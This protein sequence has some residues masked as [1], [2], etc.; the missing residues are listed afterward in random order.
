MQLLWVSILQ[1]RLVAVVDSIN[2]K[3][4]VFSQLEQIVSVRS[5]LIC[6]IDYSC[7]FQ[8]N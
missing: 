5:Y 7:S 6:I 1:S 8:A 3:L 4:S 2:E